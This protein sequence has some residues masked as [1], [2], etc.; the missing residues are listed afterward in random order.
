[1]SPRVRSSPTRRDRRSRGR[2]RRT[3]HSEQSTRI[4][5][6]MLSTT[7][8]LS[9][10]RKDQSTTRLEL[11]IRV[12]D[13][14]AIALT[15]ATHLESPGAD[16]VAARAFDDWRPVHPVDSSHSAPRSLPLKIT[17]APRRGRPRASQPP[18]IPASGHPTHFS[19][20]LTTNRRGR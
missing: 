7:P 1:V 11:S 13:A 4:C 5:L 17:P 8:D 9:I 12:T 2:L 20:R 3:E 16:P 6:F 15:G 14:A 10:F 19:S 18:Q